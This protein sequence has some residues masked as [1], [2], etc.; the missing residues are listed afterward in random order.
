MT[1]D[2][3]ALI[4]FALLYIIIIAIMCYDSAKKP[5]Y[6]MTEKEIRE[7]IRKNTK[8]YKD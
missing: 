3:L 1:S 2:V 8:K 4:I 5:N 7:L 6:F